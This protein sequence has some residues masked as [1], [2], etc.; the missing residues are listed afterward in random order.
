MYTLTVHTADGCSSSAE[1]L[2]EVISELVCYIPNVFSP[3]GDGQNDF[4]TVFGSQQTEEILQ[5]Q[6]FD[7]WGNEV[8]GAQQ[9]PTGLEQ[10]GWDGTLRGKK[11]PAGVYVYSAL[12]RF[13]NGRTQRY[14]G[15]ITLLR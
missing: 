8:F 11:A 9:L 5:L 7:R 4:F 3:N 1:I 13:K 15:D 6:I 12:I 14:T 10:V 2:V